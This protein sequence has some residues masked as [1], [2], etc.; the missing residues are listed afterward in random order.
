MRLTKCLS[1]AVALSALTFS[2]SASAQ[3]GLAAV[4][5][6]NP[7]HGFPDWYE[8]H[9]GL[10]LD[11]CIT[12]TVLCLLDGP[13]PTLIDPNL[14]F[15]DNYG[16]VWSD[17]TFFAMAEASMPTNNGG[18]ALLVLTVQGGFLN[19]AGPVDGEQEVFTRFRV[20]VDNLIPGSNYTVT[21]PYGI[22]NFIAQNAGVRG[23]NFTE[24]A[25][26]GVPGVFDGALGGQIGPF[27]M[28]DS[29]LPILDAQG[30]EYL[31]NPTIE[32]TITGS[33][34][35][36]NFF[37]IEGPS[38]GGPGVNSIQT[39][40]FAVIGLKSGVIEPPPVAPVASFTSAPNSGTAPLNVSFTDTSTG[41]IT[42]W[43]WN[44]GDGSTSAL[45]HPAHAYAAGTFSVS[46]TVTGPG[47]S[48]TATATNLVAVTEPPVGNALTLAL[49]VPGT[50]GVPNTLTVTG[51][52]P[53]RVVGVYTGQVLGASI[54]NQGSCGGI[55]L[56]LGRPFRLAGRAAA[57]AAGVAVIGV[58]PPATSAG[59]LFH[60]Q[61]IEPFSCRTSNVV[62]DRL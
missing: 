12:D 60:F 7:E 21:T 20:R 26:R 59:K 56:G 17:H 31:G 47:G 18:Q 61:A 46:L 55:P 57:N 13:P 44:F 24:D 25:G 48:N 4:G 8:D 41:T 1:G 10:R 5:P 28:W 32:H 11:A 37:R 50:A 45:Q 30:R 54:V 34:F 15:P 6:T 58:T 9:N 14:P 2:A 53:G 42:S 19:D 52:T 3:Q 38:V 40:L 29:D 33:P 27:V 35:G 51:A 16:G 22:Y 49:P 39:D 43:L 23:I 62:S 36:T